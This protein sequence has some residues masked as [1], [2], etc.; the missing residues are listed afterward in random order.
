MS[1]DFYF[2]AG[3]WEGKVLLEVARQDNGL[4]DENMLEAWKDRKHK[5]IFSL[6]PSQLPQDA[7]ISIVLQVYRATKMNHLF[8]L[9]ELIQT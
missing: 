6:D 9:I 3:N 7:L 2:P 4:Q 1:E 5:A 8:H